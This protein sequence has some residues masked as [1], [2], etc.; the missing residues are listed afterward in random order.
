M[1]QK[2]LK[3]LKNLTSEFIKNPKLIDRLDDIRIRY[4]EI[5]EKLEDPNARDKSGASRDLGNP[6][7]SR[8]VCVFSI[9]SSLKSFM[10]TILTD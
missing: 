9:P 3:D 5:T 2:S 4:A 10:E 7:F 6:N 8:K 1:N